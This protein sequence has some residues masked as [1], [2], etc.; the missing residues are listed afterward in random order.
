MR[1]IA[2]TTFLIVAGFVLPARAQNNTI[3][4]V[5]GGGVNPASPTAAYIPGVFGAVR[6]S[7]GN[8][9]ISAPT[10]NVI[11]KVTPAGTMTIFAGTGIFGDGGDGGPA[12]QAGL[13][14]PEGL[15][16]DAFGKLFIAGLFYK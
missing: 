14:F 1:R 5:A 12:L 8:T 13:D 16:P 11:Y 6:D 10:L 7:A 15:A 9:Y 4:T 2:F 3:S